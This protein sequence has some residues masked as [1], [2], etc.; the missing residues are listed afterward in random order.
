MWTF[1]IDHLILTGEWVVR[2]S[3]AGVYQRNANEIAYSK[4][5]AASLGSETCKAKNAELEARRQS[6]KDV[7]SGGIRRPFPRFVKGRWI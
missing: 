7:G 3:V 1:E 5:A 2:Y 4:D 6:G